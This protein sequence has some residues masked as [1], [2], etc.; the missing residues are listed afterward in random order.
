LN[1][2]RAGDILL[3]KGERGFSKLIAWGTGSEYTH[4]AICVSPKMRLAIEA[5]SGY[6]VRA[7]DIQEI[8]TSF[9]IYRIKAE[10]IYDLDGTISYLV[11][12]LNMK[13]DYLGVVYLGL[14]KLFRLK[15]KANKWQR[16]KDYF[17][18]ELTKKAFL[19]GGKLD[20]VPQVEAGITS[21]KDLSESK[22]LEKEVD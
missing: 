15:Q 10:Y 20:I 16:N 3:F 2:L 19:V 18:F 6:G 4:V 17:C 14:L 22:V 11:S 1:N 7:R 12:K 21:G 9:D 8:K 5:M 13:Y